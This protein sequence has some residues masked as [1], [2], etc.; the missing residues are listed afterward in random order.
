[1][2]E[3]LLSIVAMLLALVFTFLLFFVATFFRGGDE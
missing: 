1:M 3:I 2:I